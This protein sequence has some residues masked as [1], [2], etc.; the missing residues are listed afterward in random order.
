MFVDEATEV[1]ELG[2][3]GVFLCRDFDGK[4]WTRG[5]L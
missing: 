1:P 5:G 2:R 3:L 4:R